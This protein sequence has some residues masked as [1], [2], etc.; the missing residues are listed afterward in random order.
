MA[1]NHARDIKKLG[2][3]IDALRCEKGYSMRQFA[4][5]CGINKSQVNELTNL[6]VDFRY[7][8]LSKIAN[9]LDIPLSELLNF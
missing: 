2:K 4:D 6:G 1:K 7:S 8:T 9:G 5:L 3:H